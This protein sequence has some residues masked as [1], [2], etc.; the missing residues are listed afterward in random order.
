[1]NLLLLASLASAEPSAY[2]RWAERHPV[3]WMAAH[4]IAYG[5]TAWGLS[6]AVGVPL[7]VLREL[8]GLDLDRLRPGDWLSFPV[9]ETNREVALEWNT[10]EDCG[11]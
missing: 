9:T 7:P 2:E 8:S 10:V 11:C 1:M 5:E 6:Q 4:R 3:E